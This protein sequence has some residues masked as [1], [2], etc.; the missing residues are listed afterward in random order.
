[1]FDFNSLSNKNGVYVHYIFVIRV[2]QFEFKMNKKRK[3][4]LF[5]F[6]FVFFSFYK[7]PKSPTLSVCPSPGS[8]V[9]LLFKMFTRMSECV[10]QSPWGDW[11]KISTAHS[12]TWGSTTL[13]KPVL[14]PVFLFC[15]SLTQSFG[16]WSWCFQT[17]SFPAKFH[18]LHLPS[19]SL[20]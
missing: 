3:S 11:G 5:L 17:G 12:T 16:L 15:P 19:N 13:A 18:F 9:G 10:L 7:H 14:S 4:E 2:L 6:S 20:W 8:D 1:M